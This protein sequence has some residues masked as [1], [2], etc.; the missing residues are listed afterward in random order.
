MKLRKMFVTPVALAITLG[1]G[2]A[3][4][5]AKEEPKP[6]TEIY[7]Q[8]MIDAIYD[9]NRMNPTWSATMRPSQIPINCPGD[10]GCGKDGAT[11]FSIRQSTLGFKSFIPSSLGEIKTDFAFDLFGSDGGTHVHW[12]RAWAEMGMYGVGQVDSVFMD[13][14]VFPNTIDYWGPSGM[15]FVRNPQL[16]VTPINREDMKLM[17]SL[18]SPNSALD[19]G[20]VTQIDPAFAASIAPWNRYPDLLGAVRIDRDWGHFK[21]A[22]V[23]REVGFQNPGAASNDPSGHK[24]GYGVNL[25]GSFKA[26]G[27]DNLTWQLVNGSA[28]ASYMNDGGTDLAPD[29]SLHAQTVNSLGWFAYYNH[30]WAEKWSST[31][32]YS[33]HRQDNAGGQLDTAFKQGTYS[34]TNLLYYPAKN[35]TAGAEFIYGQVENKG[36][37]QAFDRRIQFSTRVTF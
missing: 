29:A 12:L 24:I 37:Q 1:A 33:Q 9:A 30:F 36:G 14:D 11:T 6:R 22:G 13:M 18:E 7:G 34:S 21:I 5:Q 15:V 8:T 23:V 32:G 17:F 3:Q 25:S 31:L 35:V 4:A 27:K 26:R 28:I 20:K 10:A 16:R 19:T 2:A